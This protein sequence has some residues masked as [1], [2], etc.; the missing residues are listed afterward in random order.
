MSTPAPATPT[1]AANPF[2]EPTPLGLLGLAVGCAALLPIAFGWALTPAALRTASYYCL[3]FGAGCQ[4]I[5]GVMSLANKNLLGGTLF[6]T[7]AFNWLINYQTLSGLAE[8]RLPDP[9][10]ILSVDVVFL[11]IFAV[12]TYAF[13]FFSKLL[14]AFLLD[15]VALFVCRIAKEALHA[16]AFALPIALATVGLMAIALYLAFAILVNSASGRPVFKVPGPLFTPT[17]P[18]PSAPVQP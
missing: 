10:V 17:P 9:H 5:A 4:F 11:V 15:I 12:L 18:A 14:F 1:P 13:G 3:F 6:T 2:A 8:G 7:F 16:P